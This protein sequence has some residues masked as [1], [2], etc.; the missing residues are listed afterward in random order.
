MYECYKQGKETEIFQ[1]EPI[2]GVLNVKDD[3]DN[4]LP[5]LEG[6]NLEIMMYDSSGKVVKQFST[7]DRSISIGVETVDDKQRGYASFSMSGAETSE[8]K[9]GHYTIE[10]ARRIDNGRGI[11]QLVGII[12]VKDAKI[13]NGV[14]L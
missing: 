10:L 13:R 7:E 9:T 11:G 12:N 3:A 1:G 6:Y 4:Y 5:S 2:G 14:S 8:L